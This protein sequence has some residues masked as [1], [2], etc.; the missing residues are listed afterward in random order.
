MNNDLVQKTVTDVTENTDAQAVEE[1][2]EG[3]LLTDTTSQNEEK[4]DVKSYTDEELKKIVNDK[5][6]EILPNKIERERR[7]IE[8][9]YRKKLSV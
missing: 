4:K 3:I 5:V 2:E 9:E 1:N 6:N 8:K 7:K